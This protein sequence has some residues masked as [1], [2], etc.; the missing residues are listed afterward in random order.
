MRRMLTSGVLCAVALCAGA[1]HAMAAP[2]PAA[3]QDPGSGLIQ[4][5]SAT[6][7]QAQLGPRPRDALVSVAAA[8][9]AGMPAADATVAANHPKAAPAE[10]RRRRTGPAM[11]IAALA[12]I[13]TIALRRLGA[14]DQ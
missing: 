12:V 11:L 5:A 1:Q 2:P 4:T 10:E 8:H 6:T 9:A 7:A 13:T 3:P 14:F